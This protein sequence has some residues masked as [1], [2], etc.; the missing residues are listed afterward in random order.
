M[1][2]ALFWEL[3]KDTGAPEAYLLYQRLR[4]EKELQ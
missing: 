2:S 4:R 3:F 1:E